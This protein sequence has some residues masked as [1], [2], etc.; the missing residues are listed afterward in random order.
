M[1][2]FDILIIYLTC[3]APIG[4]FYFLQTR[5]DKITLAGCAGT[6]LT[7]LFWIPF[8]IHLI[9]GK[10]S[11]K[12]FANKNNLE[13]KIFE[14]QKYLE[15]IL[16]INDSQIS[17]FEFRELFNRYVG[18]TIAAISETEVDD[19]KQNLF[20]IVESAN[21]N[22]GAICLARKNFQKLSFHQKQARR[23]FLRLISSLLISITDREFF[24]QTTADFFTILKDR[25]AVFILENEEFIKQFESE[26][27]NSFN[28][29]KFK[30]EKDL[31]H[32]QEIVGQTIN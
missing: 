9:N 8:L 26:N 25:E 17:I 18:L 6:I 30:Q 31:F 1:N 27:E 21:P 10:L 15:N 24:L 16:Q 32:S 20:Q 13:N 23:E 14:F 7:F 22:I 12:S 2:F 4:V 11:K 29:L 28:E 19:S 3:G 5:K